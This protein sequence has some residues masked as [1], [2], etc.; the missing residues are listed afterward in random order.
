M[1]EAS[2]L[3]IGVL[4]AN[5][6]NASAA[7]SSLTLCPELRTL[8]LSG[9]F[10]LLSH[11]LCPQLRRLNLGGHR[12]GYVSPP[13]DTD[14]TG[15]DPLLHVLSTAVLLESLCFRVAVP[16][17]DVQGLRAILSSGNLD[18]VVRCAHV[19][20]G[21]LTAAVLLAQFHL[22]IAKPWMIK[23]AHRIKGLFGRA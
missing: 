11:I 4:G 20:L 14:M 15:H 3:R 9:T 17:D 18:T 8:D 21:F 5:G 22:Q 2:A 13:D 12:S 6:P 7:P 10:T 23:E 16:R 19:L 1:G